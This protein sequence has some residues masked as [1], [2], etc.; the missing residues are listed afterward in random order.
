MEFL[1]AVA[2]FI[3]AAAGLGLG[4]AFGRGPAKSSCG[5]SACLPRDRCED[6]PLRRRAATG[7][8]PR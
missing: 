8:K 1:L 2:I 7:E 6:C 3:L 5:A 4:L